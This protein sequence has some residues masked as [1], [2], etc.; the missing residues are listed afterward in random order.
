LPTP[1]LKGKA[2]EREQAKKREE[3]ARRAAGGGFAGFADASDSDS[4]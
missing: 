1:Q 3:D 4:D 2:K